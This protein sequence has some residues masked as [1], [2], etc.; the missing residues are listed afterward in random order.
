MNPLGELKTA[1][2]RRPKDELRRL[3][4]WGPRGYFFEKKWK[5]EMEEAARRLPPLP[6]SEQREVRDIH[7]LCGRE[8]WYQAAFCAWTYQRHSRYRIRPVVIDDG[9][10]D[11]E[12]EAA[13]CAV[14]P[15]TVVRAKVTCDEKFKDSLP[16]SQYPKVHA[17]RQRQILFRKLTDVFGFDNE[18]RLLFDADMLFF[19]PPVEIDNTLERRSEIMVQR[20]CWESYGY[21]RA[22]TESLTGHT[23]PEAINIGMLLYNGRLTD[24]DR[25]EH[26]LGVL[27]DKEGRP[28]NVTQCMFAMLLAGRTIE[29]LDKEK[30]KVLARSPGRMVGGRIAEH[31][32]ADSKPWYYGYAWRLAS[33]P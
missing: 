9:T 32:V 15:E 20:D 14:F 23:L 4:A 6:A 26:W 28:Y 19:A 27:E 11:A 25:V 3:F 1:L 7:F 2:Y 8:H 22:L 13:F 17:W 12:T 29:V 21:S 33:R 30:Y 5:A 18:W 16:E 10:M 24:W 31:Y